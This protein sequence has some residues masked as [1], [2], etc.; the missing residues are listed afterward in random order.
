MKKIYQNKERF[1]LI[2]IAVKQ[3]EC[4][5]SVTINSKKCFEYMI[6]QGESTGIYN[7][8]Y[9]A[10]IPVE[11]ESEVILEGE[12]SKPFWDAIAFSD[13]VP[14]NESEHPVVHFAPN[15][16]WMNDPNGFFYQDGVYHLYFQ[17]N[18]MNK[19][20]GN[21]SWGHATSMDLLHWEQQEDVMFPDERGTMFSGC[22]VL[23]DK[24]MLNLPE[25][26]PLFFYTC[27]GGTSNWSEGRP[28]TQQ[29]AW[30]P[31]KG[32][33]LIKMNS[34]VVNQICDG[35]RDPKIY[36]HEESK[37]YYMILYLDKNE[38]AILR[39]DNL[40]NWRLTQQFSLDGAWE[41]PDLRSISTKDGESAWVFWCADGY[42]WIGD[43]DGYLFT[44]ISER[45]EAYL[46]ALPY[47]AQTCVGEERVISIP[48]MRTE[49]AV[50]PYTGIM[51]L[52]R[53]LGLV[54][55][56]E[57]LLLQLKPV[58]ELLEHRKEILWQS[59]G[60]LT[61]EINFDYAIEVEINVENEQ[62]FQMQLGKTEVSW[63][64]K[65]NE[66]LIS[67][68]VFQHS[69]SEWRNVGGEV[70]EGKIKKINLHREP[71]KIDLLIDK[72]ILEITMDNGLECVAVE[73][74]QTNNTNMET[75]T[76]VGGKEIKL[77]EVK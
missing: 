37:G 26:C 56:Q 29:L 57:E 8:Q 21:M 41:C 68:C 69:R 39:S 4:L 55:E 45:K 32:K 46:T 25:H 60:P 22:A 34:P 33:T 10:A 54:R 5:L 3:T 40:M 6:P 49:N 9:Y 30:S 15:T 58:K 11:S 77:Y 2:P 74:E 13:T 70:E 72:E 27:A 73:L 7:F 76:V 52:P 48:W 61:T 59:E 47:A 14:K 42:Y 23:N 17:H 28:Y 12:F 38:F 67:N 44:P 63:N 36:W 16:G 43:F 53:E 64:K 18:P 20:W 1:L 31:D 75:V 62:G 65:D 51:G 50:K 71:A 66:L 35:N 19:I 24:K